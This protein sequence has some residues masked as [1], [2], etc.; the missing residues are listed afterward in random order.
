MNQFMMMSSGSGDAG[1][2]ITLSTPP[3]NNEWRSLKVEKKSFKQKC[4]LPGFRSFFY[5]FKRLKDKSVVERRASEPSFLNAF[6]SLHHY[7]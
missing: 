7:Y 3:E 6:D 4:R 1:D 5:M 2:R